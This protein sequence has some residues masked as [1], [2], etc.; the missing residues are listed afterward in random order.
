MPSQIWEGI[1]LDLT[2][3]KTLLLNKFNFESSFRACVER[4]EVLG[5]IQ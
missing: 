2:F 3:S 1:F 5:F 4:D